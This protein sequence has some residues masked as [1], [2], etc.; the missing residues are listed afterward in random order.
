MVCG[1]PE[2]EEGG[3]AADQQ[4]AARRVRHLQLA[5]RV[6][7]QVHGA[8]AHLEAPRLAV[9]DGRRRRRRFD[10]RDRH[11]VVDQPGWSGREHRRLP[12]HRFSPACGVPGWWRQDRRSFDPGPKSSTGWP[13]HRRDCDGEHDPAH[14]DSRRRPG[15]ARALGAQHPAVAVQRRRRRA[16]PASRRE[17]PPAVLWTPTAASRP[18]AAARPST[19]P[20]WPSG[21]RASTRRSRWPGPTADPSWSGSEGYRATG[22]PR[23]SWLRGRRPGPGTPRGAAS[24]TSQSRPT[25]SRHCGMRPRRRAPGSASSSHRRTRSRWQCCC[26]ARTR[27]S[28]TT[29]P[30][31][32][33]WRP[34][35]PAQGR[36]RRCPR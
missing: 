25:R 19:W 34:G 30:T 23:S 2:V 32:P 24:T 26:P 14:P 21:C 3:T 9:V 12:S 1:H 16:D 4:R 5:G 7:V 31:A 22:R 28:R 8:G 10:Q 33:S 20:G 36:R 35:P 18:S 27:R 15:P 29:R 17:P 11:V 13:P 6:G